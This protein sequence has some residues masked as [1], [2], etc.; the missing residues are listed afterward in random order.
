LRLLI[1]STILKNTL[2]RNHFG[3]SLSEDNEK[4]REQRYKLLFKASDLLK[5]SVIKVVKLC[6]LSFIIT[7]VLFF[8]S[9]LFYIG[10]PTSE[11]NLLRLISIFRVLFLILI[12]SK[13]LPEF[14]NLHRKKPIEII[15]ELIVFLLSFC[16]LL[17]NFGIVTSN[18]PFWALLYGNV[19]IISTMFI[20]AISEISVLARFISSINIPP[21][22]LFSG[23]FLIIIFIGSGLLMLPLAHNIPLTFLDSLFT[24][25][26]A[27]CVTGL[28][29]VDTATAFTPLGKMII[30][31]LIQVGGL[32]IMTF[33]GFFSFIFTSGS[34]YRDRLLLKEIFSSQSLDN[35]FKL[36]T[37][38][39]L[40]TFL[41]EIAGAIIIY[42]SLGKDSDYKVLFSIFHSVSA[43][44]NA[45]FSTLSD[46]LNSTGIRN[47]Y[48]VQITIALLIILGGIGFPVLL[49]IY[50][51]FRQTI[52]FLIRKVLR[53]RIYSIHNQMNISGRM[54]VFM[55]FILI[56][57]GTVLYYLFESG[58]SI[59]GLNS[60]DKLIVSFFG[61]VSARTAGFNVVDITRWSYPTIFLMIVLMWIGASPGST[62]GGIKTTTFAIA[63]RSAI[64]S[65]KG[66]HHLKIGNREISSNTISRVLAIIFLSLLVITIGFFCLMFSE[67]S[68]DPAHLLF[69]AVSAFGTVGLSIA[70][71]STFSQIGKIV[72]IFL[73]FIGRVGPLTL[74]TGFFLSNKVK[75][76]R[77]PEIEIVIN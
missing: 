10:F 57:A 51:F 13:F 28:V 15:F 48:L 41:T 75:Y 31:C 25:V 45:G 20:I 33:T 52:I 37:K 11:E 60:G 42:Y 16:V 62:G 35:L 54:A 56:I 40:W 47:N 9:F 55:T 34:S 22:L 5:S 68:K 77:Y 1:N 17:S 43:F 30:L 71:T 64:N 44:C 46:G 4:K 69:E 49:N 73:M 7:I 21:A 72:L 66:R 58:N 63:F 38:I 65:I 39:I 59:S 23:S 24:S 36:L 3:M 12:I 18:R 61:S 29:V 2:S 50:S 74:L 8:A 6:H 70:N 26:S 19:P 27:V 76:S 53:K 32:G 67:R 14:L